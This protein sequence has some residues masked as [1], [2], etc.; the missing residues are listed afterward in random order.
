MTTIFH[1]EYVWPEITALVSRAGKTHAAIA[2]LGQDA[3]QLLPLGSKDVLVVNAGARNIA[4]HATN[5]YAIE[6]FILRG[7]DVYSSERLHAKVIATDSHAIVGSANASTT[8]AKSSEAVVVSDNKAIRKQV[9]SFVEHEI[10]QMG[11]LIT[12]EKVEDLKKLFNDSKSGQEI[13]GV[14]KPGQEPHDFPWQLGRV[15]LA[16]RVEADLVEEEI[17]EIMSGSA[18]VTGFRT[19]AIQLDS[20]EEKYKR[21]DIVFFCDDDYFYPPI[22]V[23]SG[24]IK[25][26]T[27]KTRMGQIT[28]QRT[29]KGRLRPSTVAKRLKSE[30]ISF[31]DLLQSLDDASDRLLLKGDRIEAMVK[32]WFPEYVAASLD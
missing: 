6:E 2:F 23:D 17:A 28:Q 9:R 11:T 16:F 20:S 26:K 29:G 32:I 15:Y 27:D 10:R 21:G 3:P 8:S 18:R 31:E 5:P 19:D 4:A 7:V 1:A 25:T 24:V 14:T 13:T 12:P 22:L 30:Q